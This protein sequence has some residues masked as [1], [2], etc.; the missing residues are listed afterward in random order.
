MPEIPG[1]EDVSRI[2]KRQLPRDPG[3]VV[4]RGA[5]NQGAAEIARLGRTGIIAGAEIGRRRE[6][7]LARLQRIDDAN[8]ITRARNAL[9]REGTEILNE[10]QNADLSTATAARPFID[11]FAARVE[12][13][14]A[15][16]GLSEEAQADI[17]AI[18]ERQ[19]TVFQGEILGLS[20]I[21]AEEEAADNI[22]T[23]INQLG[24][25]SRR[26]PANR[27]LLLDRAKDVAGPF[28]QDI[29]ADAERDLIAEAIS[30]VV[31]GVILGHLDRGDVEA[32]RV[33]LASEAA[34]LVLGTERRNELARRIEAK[35][36][37]APREL[38]QGLF[39]DA[40]DDEAG[41]DMLGAMLKNE[42]RFPE[43][44]AG[45]RTTALNA[46]EARL[47][48]LRVEADRL[49]NEEVAR[50]R[51]EAGADVIKLSELLTELKDASNFLGADD[52]TRLSAIN[53][54][55]AA[56]GQEKE[57]QDRFGLAQAR[58]Q[59]AVNGEIMLDPRGEDDRESVDLIF[60]AIAEEESFQAL[61]PEERAAVTI[62]FIKTTGLVPDVVKS[63]IRATL[64]SG[65]DEEI[66]AAAR[67]MDILN[68]ERPETLTDFSTETR[69]FGLEVVALANAGVEPASAVSLARKAVFDVSPTE[70]DERRRRMVT[71][72]FEAEA[73]GF[74]AKEASKSDFFG[75]IGTDIVIPDIAMGDFL[76]TAK[77]VFVSTGGEIK[78]S[79]EIAF[80]EFSRIYAVSEVGGPK[81][82]M[83]F[84]PEAM[85][86]VPQLS[87]DENTEFMQEQLVEEMA[88][89]FAG[90]KARP[91]L[92]EDLPA[93]LT[94]RDFLDDRLRIHVDALTE[95]QFPTYAVFLL[96]D[97]NFLVP[98]LDGQERQLRWVPD[99][100][101]SP[102]V[103]RQAEDLEKRLAA[104][105]TA[106]EKHLA[107]DKPLAVERLRG[108]LGGS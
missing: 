102:L 103:K 93:D 5:L 61:E 70:R 94:D 84:A 2:P 78:T 20:R 27:D 90:G 98:V 22:S 53:G 81:R 97:S 67:M 40:R 56:L 41:L 15:Q 39:V 4:P 30:V 62:D 58:V 11:Q 47:T 29:D 33:E 82:F 45:D 32:A 89:R 38:V 8:G 100:A 34:A 105:Q 23:T 68:K 25:E 46:V 17:T 48:N 26:L 49:A 72:S 83:R 7:E 37:A 106:R 51:I 87:H 59:A 19:F 57:R 55:S 60:R 88:D 96:N 104:A 36:E 80:Q 75:L 28:R 63:N 3:V 74:L 6:A 66:I 77:S 107:G 91:A 95:L 85:F 43:L 12:T 86:H 10:A 44:S 92:E 52:A 65:S 21:A 101:T 13:A 108:G 71:E 14:K 73:R 50:R 1:P 24:E 99:V 9:A 54:I 31:T 76:T 69:A 64:R 16:P 42:A 18:A 79:F 35:A